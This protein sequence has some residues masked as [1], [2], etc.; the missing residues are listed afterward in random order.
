MKFGDLLNVVKSNLSDLSTLEN[1]DFRLEQ[2]EFLKDEDIWEV[3]VSYLVENTNRK[4][5]TALGALTSGGF[6]YVRLYKLV[7]INSDAEV[8]GLFMYNN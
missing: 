5:T 1:P 6:E 8:V 7:K 4:V 2:A 3:V